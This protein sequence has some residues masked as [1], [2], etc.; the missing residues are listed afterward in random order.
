MSCK[1][2]LLAALAA[3]MLAPARPACAAEPFKFGTAVS[4]DGQTLQVDGTGILQN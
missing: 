2:L 4:P 1:G 3:A